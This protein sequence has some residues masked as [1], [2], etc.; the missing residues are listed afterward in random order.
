[1]TQLATDLLD[2]IKKVVGWVTRGQKLDEREDIVQEVWVKL[3][4]AVLASG[5]SARFTEIRHRAIDALRALQRARRVKLVG[6]EFMLQVEAFNQAEV[7]DKRLEWMQDA[8]AEERLNTVEGRVVYKM[9]YL[10]ERIARIA[11]EMGMSM[12]DV[13]AVRNEVLERLGRRIEEKMRAEE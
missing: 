3:W 4:P 2:R 5:S 11:V 10:G 1:M 12:S 7:V 8:L 13:V 6:E 9:F